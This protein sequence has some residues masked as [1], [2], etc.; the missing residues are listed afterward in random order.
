MSIDLSTISKSYPFLSLARQIGV[1]YSDVLLIA[2]YFCGAAPHI[3][4][5][6]RDA[7]QR[8]DPINRH[9]ICQVAAAVLNGEIGH[10]AGTSAPKPCPNCGSPLWRYPDGRDT[11]SRCEYDQPVEGGHGE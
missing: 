8:V 9:K 3:S 6:Q 1:D 7:V 10:G 5:A 11:C 2:E 4:A